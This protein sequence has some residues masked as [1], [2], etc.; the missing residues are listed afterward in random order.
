MVP[1]SSVSDEMRKALKEATD[2]MHHHKVPYAL[3]GGIAASYRSQP[4]FTKDIDFLVKVPQLVL[5]S[6]L[7]DL[8]CRGFEFDTTAT[9]GEWTQHHMATL[10]YHG[11]RID[12]LK[13]LI[14]AYLHILERATEEPWLDQPVRIASA[15]GLILLKLIAFRSQDQLDIENL[16]A[17]NA[18]G[19]D[20]DWIKMEWQTLADLEDPRMRRLLELVGEPRPRS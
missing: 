10:S 20:L 5:P 19:L 12:W 14:P 17:A 7:E 18:D 2:A 9:I 8:R 11:I 4:R 3:I 16:V 13:A 15:E 6:L 1:D